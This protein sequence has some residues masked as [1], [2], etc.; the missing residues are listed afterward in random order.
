MPWIILAG[1]IAC[2][3]VAT[4][5]LRGLADGFRIGPTLLVI[6]GYAMSFVLMAM[7]LRSLNVGLVYA[8]WS[9]AGTAAVAGVAAVLYGEHLNLT[10]ITGM[11]LIVGG[12]VVLAFSG[13]AG[14]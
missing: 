8:I 2:E 7:A 10:A 11:L 9:G 5:T 12:V 13:A 1:A 6:A 14:H 3:V 4:L